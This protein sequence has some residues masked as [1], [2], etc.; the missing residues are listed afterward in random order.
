[1]LPQQFAQHTSF[2]VLE[3]TPVNVEAAH[4]LTLC[5]PPGRGYSKGSARDCVLCSDKT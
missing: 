1:M 2:E 4:A 3:G 5:T